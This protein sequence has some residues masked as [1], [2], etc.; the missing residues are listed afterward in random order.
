MILCKN[1]G[2]TGELAVTNEIFSA[3]PERDC[4]LHHIL[5]FVDIWEAPNTDNGDPKYS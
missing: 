1:C 2:H 5:A 4:A 3:E